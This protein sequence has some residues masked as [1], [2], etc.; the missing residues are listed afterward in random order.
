MLQ[1]FSWVLA[2]VL[3]LGGI[4]RGQDLEVKVIQGFEGQTK[5]DVWPPESAKAEAKTDWA[6]EGKQSIFLHKGTM[7]AVSEMATHDWSEYQVWRFHVRV[8][9]TEGVALGLELGDKEPG[10]L[11]RMQTAASAPPGESVVTVD[12]SGDLWRGEVNKPYRLVKTPLDKKGIARFAITAE[13][14][15]IYVDQVELVKIKQIAADGA[16]AFSLGGPGKIIQGQWI[17]IK[18]SSAWDEAKGYGMTPGATFL[19]KTTPYPTAVM[20]GGLIMNNASLQVKLKEGKY[21]GWAIFERSGFW[22]NYQGLFTR[23][24][25][26]ANDQ[27][28]YTRDGKP[29]DPFFMLQDREVMDQQGVLQM[30]MDRQMAGDFAFTAS[31]G[32]NSFTMDVEGSGEYPP[33]LAGLVLAPDTA[34]GREFIA[35]HKK[36]QE[37]TILATHRLI[38]RRERLGDP[39]QATEPL[40]V[41]PLPS[42]AKMHPGDWPAATASQPVPAMQSMAGL[43]A[44]RVLGVYGKQDFTGLK[45]VLSELKGDAGAIPAAAVRLL[46]NNY[47]PVHGYEQ[48]ACWV[49]THDYR[50]RDLDVRPDL[51][52]AL[53]IMVDVPADAKPGTYS[54]TLELT[55]QGN[56]VKSI[57]I[58]L[59]VS[60]GTVP[61]ADMSI[62]LFF[63]GVTIPKSVLGEQAYWQLTES[64]LQQLHRGSFTMVTGGPNFQ[65]KWEGNTPVVSGDDAVKFLTMAKKYGLARIMTNYGGL[66]LWQG[67]GAPT[68]PGMSEADALSALFK[69][70]EA[71]R[72]KNGL[73]D[74]LVYC[75]DEPGTDSE[76]APVGAS[77]KALRAAGF[78]TIGYTSMGSPDEV[79]D[80][81]KMLAKETTNPAFN[82]HSPATLKYVRDLGNEPWIYNNGLNRM[83]IGVH[84][85]RNHRYGAGGR[86]DW[87][88]SIIQG[89]QYDALDSREPDLSCFYFHKSQ[90]VLITPLF[91]GALEGGVDARLLFE[92]ERRAAAKP[93][94]P[95]AAKILALFKSIEDRPYGRGGMDWSALENLRGQMLGL[96][97]ESSK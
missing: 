13:S 91:A 56:A 25:L 37:E 34:E 52:R 70:W 21:I 14:G 20:G 29:E 49:E 60:A 3:A 68:V 87:I 38:D 47:M 58:A 65:I 84:L 31:A 71:F 78:K 72:A 85:W 53:L 55:R 76:F 45:P 9:G 26:K 1:R 51:A 90:G 63:S 8:P 23:L 22:E 6:T 59:K 80:N 48:T 97:E 16:Y 46:V 50:T 18:D 89:F 11:N 35:A 19:D 24:T 42:D 66:Y 81:H 57:P 93:D 32:R 15:D 2:G 67:R 54:G 7:I 5:W 28:V 95:A 88:G 73:P 61:L 44:C 33:R 94:Q 30:V 12:I 77:L 43:T 4:A 17:G 36:L 41:I 69:A 86:I 82:G 27:A 75:Y 74:Y 62:G 96:M 64:L 40:L 92:L 10:N 79:N 83:G 39:A